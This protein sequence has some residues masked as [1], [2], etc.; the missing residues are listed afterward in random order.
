M[1][2]KWLVHGEGRIQNGIQEQKKYIN[3]IKWNKIWCSDGLP[4]VNAF[5]S[6]LSCHKTLTVENLRKRGIVGPSRCILCKE[7]KENLEYLFTV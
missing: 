3:N 6:I 2:E 1:G 5:F 7:A 4:K